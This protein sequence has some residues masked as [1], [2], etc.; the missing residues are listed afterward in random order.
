MTEPQVIRTYPN[1]PYRLF[2]EERFL[3]GVFPTATKCDKGSPGPLS[4][5]CARNKR[6]SV[7]QCAAVGVS[8]L[9]SVRAAQARR[10]RGHTEGHQERS[11][12]RSVL[13]QSRL[14]PSAPRARWGA[15]RRQER[16]VPGHG[17]RG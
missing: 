13:T 8:P 3:G 4:A 14:L 7:S 15:G 2:S 12:K 16:N 10:A 11:M 5:S 9:R 1:K 17:V 6:E